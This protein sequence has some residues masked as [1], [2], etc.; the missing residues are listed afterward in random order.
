MATQ[1]QT[2]HPGDFSP[3]QSDGATH[4]VSGTNEIDGWVFDGDL[5]TNMGVQGVMRLTN[6]G[7]GNLTFTLPIYCVAVTNQFRMRIRIARVADGSHA[8]E[9]VTFGDW[10][11]VNFTPAG[12][13]LVTKDCEIAVTDTESAAADDNILVQI[14]REVE[15]TTNDTMADEAVWWG[16]GE[17][18]YSDT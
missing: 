8:P 7:S 18:S 16:P 14:E 10:T 1:P 2:L 12:T 5:T 3:Y 6:Y 11:E 4:Q 13:T 9:T 17:L 15:D